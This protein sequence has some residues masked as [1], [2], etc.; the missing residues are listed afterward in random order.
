MN[1]NRTW[2]SLCS[3]KRR[4]PARL[5]G[6]TRLVVTTKNLNS[7]FTYG[8]GLYDHITQFLS[9]TSRVSPSAS[10]LPPKT[11]QFLLFLFHRFGADGAPP[12]TRFGCS[13]R[14]APVGRMVRAA[15]RRANGAEGE[16]PAN[17]RRG[18]P[19]CSPSSAVHRLR[20]ARAGLPSLAF[21][22]P[23]RSF[24]RRRSGARRPSGPSPF[25]LSDTPRTSFVACSRPLAPISLRSPRP[26]TPSRSSRTSRGRPCW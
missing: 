1:F 18:R 6:G 23:D 2:D 26:S 24:R 25:A 22:G 3:T 16:G 15:M 21:A 11:P 4:K 5:R 17:E 19:S 7:V 8:N 13:A 14:R 9:E 12:R 10:L 20:P